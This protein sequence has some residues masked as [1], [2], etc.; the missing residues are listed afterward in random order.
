[1]DT[2]SKATGRAIPGELRLHIVILSHCLVLGIMAICSTFSEIDRSMRSKI[3]IEVCLMYAGVIN[4]STS[5]V[6]HD[7]FV[8]KYLMLD[9]L[10][11]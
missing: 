9:G 11:L 3:N 7:G 1:M 4:A 8:E 5:L 2:D 10:L 6:S